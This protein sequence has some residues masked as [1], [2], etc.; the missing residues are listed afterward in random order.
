VKCSHSLLAAALCLALAGCSLLERDYR[1]LEPHSSS[2][3]DETD[4]NALR[5]A[6]YQD[7]VNA[8]LL[9]A[10]E[11]QETGRLHLY[12]EEIVSAW[13]MLR[14]ARDEILQQTA[15]GFMPSSSNFSIHGYFSYLM[16]AFSSS[17]TP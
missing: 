9:L 11:R 12:E 17:S 10:E 5:A 6:S 4:E 1:T 16:A 7:L 15:A 14:D 2:Y 8:I 13:T 3:R